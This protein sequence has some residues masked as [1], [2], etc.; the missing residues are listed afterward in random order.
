MNPEQFDDAILRLGGMHM[1][2]SFI[3]SDGTLMADSGLSES[4]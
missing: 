1:S 3:R 4:L 2:M